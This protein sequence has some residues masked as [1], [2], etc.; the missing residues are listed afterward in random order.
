MEINY[1]FN[2][3]SVIFVEVSGETVAA[4]LKIR[5]NCEMK[6]NEF[7]TFVQNEP[8]LIKCARRKEK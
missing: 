4:E 5:L 7:F 8:E 2:T 1:I 6:C 3:V